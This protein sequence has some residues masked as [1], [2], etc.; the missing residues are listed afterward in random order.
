[1]ALP[2]IDYLN[3]NKY[4]GVDLSKVGVKLAKEYIASST[5][6]KAL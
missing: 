1:M 5:K 6:K 2:F 3:D 4:I